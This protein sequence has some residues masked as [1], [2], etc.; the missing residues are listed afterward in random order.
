MCAWIDWASAFG[1]G[2]VDRVGVAVLGD[3]AVLGEQHRVLDEAPAGAAQRPV[4]LVAV[5]HV[6]GRELVAGRPEHALMERDGDLAPVLVE[7]PFLGLGRDQVGE[8]VL[9]GLADRGG[10][11]ARRGRAAVAIDAD[12]AQAG[13]ELLVDAVGAARPGRRPAP[14][15]VEGASA[16]MPWAMRVER[17]EAQQPAPGEPGAAGREKAA[18][19]ERWRSI[20]TS[21]ATAPPDHRCLLPRPD[22]IAR[23]RRSALV[24]RPRSRRLDGAAGSTSAFR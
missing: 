15:G 1:P 19:R 21:V 10:V 18:P 14:A 5:E 2:H 9:E 16:G 12:R 20:T 17:P 13:V 3:D 8:V 4:A 22:V 23:L 7:L 24:P 11:E 6:V